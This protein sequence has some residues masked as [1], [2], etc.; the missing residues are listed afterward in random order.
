MSVEDVYQ[1]VRQTEEKVT[2]M[3]IM[4]VIMELRMKGIIKEE[5]GYYY[6]QGYGRE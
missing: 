4:E 5:N 2:L 3:E 1:K 6:R